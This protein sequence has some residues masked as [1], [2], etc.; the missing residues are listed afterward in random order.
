MPDLTEPTLQRAHLVESFATSAARGGVSLG[1]AVYSACCGTMQS[2]KDVHT[3]AVR[4][5]ITDIANRCAE[6]ASL[7]VLRDNVD[8]SVTLKRTFPNRCAETASLAVLV[9][10]KRSRNT[11]RPARGSNSAGLLPGSGLLLQFEAHTPTDPQRASARFRR[12]FSTVTLV[13]GSL[14]RCM[15]FMIFIMVHSVKFIFVWSVSHN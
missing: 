1:A 7:A 15:I 8:T 3:A 13:H 10:D 4:Y 9:G 6:T 5:M 14:S 12:G 11:W 2:G